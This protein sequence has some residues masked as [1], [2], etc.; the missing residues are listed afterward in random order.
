MLIG[1][2]HLGV[3]ENRQGSILWRASSNP[4]KPISS[5]YFHEVIFFGYFK[6]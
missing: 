1:L 6:G 5:F 4:L 3:G 2:W